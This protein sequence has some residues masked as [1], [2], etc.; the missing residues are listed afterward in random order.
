MTLEDRGADPSKD[1]RREGMKKVRQSKGDAILIPRGYIH[2]R[3][4]A[5]K[6]DGAGQ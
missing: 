6:E 1:P 3:G 5:S 4:K 2:G